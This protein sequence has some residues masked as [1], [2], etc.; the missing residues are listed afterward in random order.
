MA[1]TIAKDHDEKRAQILRAAARV[2]ATEGFDRAS[3]V[4]VA[5]GCGI[6][7][8]NLYHYY[9]G[10]DAILFGILDE[11]LA[12]LRDRV[13]GLDLS[14]MPPDEALQTCLREILL[15]YEGADHEH[16]LQVDYTDKL[17][18]EQQQA[19]RGYQ[20][21][22]VGF[23]SA[24]LMRNAPQV[25]SADAEKLRAA[26]MSVFGM[27]NWFYMWNAGADAAERQRYAQLVTRMTLGGLPA[28]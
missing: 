19:L 8:A 27:L 11:H 16:R 12:T 15:A 17:A 3:M 14:G 2:F 18:P 26:T 21:E 24:L 7:K 6:S 28:I 22:L 5:E 23:V 10:K 1:R 4:Q 13:C 20:K 9:G 25:F